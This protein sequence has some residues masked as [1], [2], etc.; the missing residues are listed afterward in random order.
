MSSVG[1]IVPPCAKFSKS[2]FLESERI[3]YSIAVIRTQVKM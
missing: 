3:I 1:S 2:G